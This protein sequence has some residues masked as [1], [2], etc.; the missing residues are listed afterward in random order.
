MATDVDRF[1]AEMRERN[2]AENARHIRDTFAI[3]EATSREQLHAFFHMRTWGYDTDQVTLGTLVTVGTLDKRPICIS[4]SWD[5]VI[6]MG[7]EKRLVCF[8]EATSEVVDRAMIF[9]W[10]AKT[11]PGKVWCDAMNLRIAMNAIDESGCKPTRSRS[12]QRPCNQCGEIVAARNLGLR[13]LAFEIVPEY[14]AAIVNR[15]RQD[16]LPFAPPKPAEPEQ[17]PLFAP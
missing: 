11:W 16:M 1:H 10:L 4:L 14:C 3:V 9:K 15:L 7:G 2:D 6:G 13:V 8:Y 5:W 12:E 17:V